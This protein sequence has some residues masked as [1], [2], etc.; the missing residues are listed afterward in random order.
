VIK[1]RG[2]SRLVQH[3]WIKGVLPIRYPL[4]LAR[5]KTT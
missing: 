4:L 3:R 1:V 2:R 5:G